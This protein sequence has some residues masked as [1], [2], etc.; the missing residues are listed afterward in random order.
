M[1]TPQ[2]IAWLLATNLV[3][4]PVLSFPSFAFIAHMNQRGILLF[5]LVAWT[6]ATVLALSLWRKVPGTSL[7]AGYPIAL[8]AA[9]LPVVLAWASA[10][11]P[12]YWPD[13]ATLRHLWPWA[14]DAVGLGGVFT[15]GYWLPASVI[16]CLVLRRRAHEHDVRAMT[17]HR[18]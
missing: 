12:L 2:R 6:T 9:F 16:N 5:V 18:P 1:P 8:G 4:L 15:A 17:N 14:R 13:H 3:A 11:H 7:W 10:L